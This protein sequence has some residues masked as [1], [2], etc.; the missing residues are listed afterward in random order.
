MEIPKKLKVELLYDPAISFLNIYPK[1]TKLLIEK[2][3][4][5]PIFIAAALVKIWKQSQCP[6]IEEWIKNMCSIYI[7]PY[8]HIYT[9]WNT[10]HEK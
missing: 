9:Q 8:I 7:I 3:I 5:T 4:H 10:N 2:D 1:K 6:L